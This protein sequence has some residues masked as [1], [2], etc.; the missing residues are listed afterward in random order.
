MLIARYLLTFDVRGYHEARVVA[1]AD[2][3]YAVLRS[4]DLNRPWIVQAL[5]IIRSLPSRSWSARPYHRSP[6][7]CWSRRWL[8]VEL[9]SRRRRA[10]S[11]LPER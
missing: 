6:G 11:W 7:H 10:A 9:F 5:F 1:P 8:S 2:T 3:A 4:L